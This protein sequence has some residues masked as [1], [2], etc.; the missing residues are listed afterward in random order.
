M[1]TLMFYTTNFLLRYHGLVSYR[2]LLAA[3]YCR[4]LQIKLFPPGEVPAP[5]GSNC[6][7]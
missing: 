1:A 3:S 5:A 4:E 6:K 7:T 2:I